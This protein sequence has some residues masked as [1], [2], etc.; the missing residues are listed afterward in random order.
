MLCLPNGVSARFL[1]LLQAWKHKAAQ[2]ALFGWGGGLDEIIS[3]WSPFIFCNLPSDSSKSFSLFFLAYWE[4][5]LTFAGLAQP[6]D[7]VHVDAGLGLVA[8]LNKAEGLKVKASDCGEAVARHGRALLHWTS[9]GHRLVNASEEAAAI[10]EPVWA[11]IPGEEVVLLRL[12]HV[13]C[14]GRSKAVIQQD[15]ETANR[16]EEANYNI[17]SLI[18]LQ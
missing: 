3:L 1:L 9:V 11:S 2:Y 10:S 16:T 6:Q 13:V 5:L 4:Q 7:A 14:V 12:R 8:V 18:H 15:I 17:C